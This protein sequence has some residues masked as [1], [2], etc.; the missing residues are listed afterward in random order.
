MRRP[1]EL[2]KMLT[3]KVLNVNGL[4][5]ITEGFPIGEAYR[6]IIL[7]LYCNLTHGTGSGP[8]A[9]G[10][11]L[12]L[13]SLTLRTENGWIPFNGVCG[14]ALKVLDQILTGT[15]PANS[16]F[17]ATTAIYQA[18]FN[19]W[20][21]DPLMLRPEDT[22]L[23]TSVFNKMQLDLNVGSLADL[24]GT[25]GTDT[26][27]F[28][29]D[30]FVERVKGK[31]PDRARPLVYSEY[32]QPAPVNP[33][34]DTAMNLERSN[35]RRYKRIIAH[36]AN[37]ASVGTPFTGTPADTTISDMGVESDRGELI[38]RIPWN[39]LNAKMKSDFKVETALAGHAVF[40]F[41]QDLS[42]LSA[43]PSG[44]FSRLALKWTNG[45]LSTSQVSAVCQ[46]LKVI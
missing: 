42:N 5:P 28:S 40:D 37:S 22:L 46:T 20:F 31:L 2:V 18:V 32:F 30:L 38:H 41:C 23:D 43:V 34:S 13:K 29:C 45:T 12:F 27:V 14:R 36:A 10:L 9:D 26:A 3:G 35:D 21:A 6:R 24:L 25:V 11:L 39:V 15:L 19:L 8:V 16:A 44:I 33:A 4:N 17:A 1:Y 7:V